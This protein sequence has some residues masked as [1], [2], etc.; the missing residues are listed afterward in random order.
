M[1]TAEY[2]YQGGRY[3]YVVF[4]C[5]LA[6]EKALKGLYFER[7]R[8]IPPKSHSLLYLLNALGIVP[9]EKPGKFFAKLSE[10]SIPT[11]YPEDLAKVQQA[12]TVGVVKDILT[13]TRETIAWIRTQFSR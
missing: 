8:E 9:P 12:Y 1:D 6:V 13:A 11:R 7:R 2:M 3:L 10:A 4:L 5:H